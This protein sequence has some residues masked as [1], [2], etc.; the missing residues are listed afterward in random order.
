MLGYSFMRERIINNNTLASFEYIDELYGNN[1]DT[2]YIDQSID[3]ERKL[4][5]LKIS[6]PS[7]ISK[8]IEE[9]Q[10]SDS[11]MFC[12][13]VIGASGGATSSASVKK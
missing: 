9:I 11:E 3:N 5:D 10:L 8:I 4:T 6:Y 7:I 13:S 12:Y 1:L 2:Y